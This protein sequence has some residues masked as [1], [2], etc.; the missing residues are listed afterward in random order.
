MERDETAPIADQI[1]DE[2]LPEDLDWRRLVRN[3]PLPAL[4]VA[5]LG[6]FWLGRR[7]GPE[8]VSAVADYA[9]N[10]VSTTV[11]SFLGEGAVEL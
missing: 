6:G 9:R 10:Q 4:A 1:F 2:L 11:N 7:H 3:Y 8:L 5:A